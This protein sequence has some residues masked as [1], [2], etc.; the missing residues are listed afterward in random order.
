MNAPLLFGHGSNSRLVSQLA[1][2]KWEAWRI[3][4]K[5]SF[6]SVNGRSDLRSETGGTRKDAVPDA[7]AD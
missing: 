1:I 4:E 2:E 3:S 5:N 6:F 7:R